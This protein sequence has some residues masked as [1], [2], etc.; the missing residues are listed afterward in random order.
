MDREIKVVIGASYGDEG[1]GFMTDY[2]CK[3]ADKPCITVLHNG[4][5]QRG[6]TVISPD[7]RR[8]VF[9]HFG[10]GTFN[11]SD[12]YF[13]DSFI[14]NPMIF[15]QEYK[16]LK[17]DINI[18]CSPT[19]MWSTPFDMMINQIIEDSRGD[20]RHGSCG[21]GIWETIVRCNNSET[22][23]FP[24][25]MLM[26]K[27][28]KIDYLRNIRDKYMPARLKEVGVNKIPAEWED[29]IYRDSIITHFI[30]DCIFFSGKIKYAGEYIPE[31]YQSVVFE[32]GQGL[33]LS[34]DND[35][36]HTTPSFTG[37]ENPLRIINQLKG[38][39]NIEVC[40]VTRSYLTR[41]GAGGFPHEC[42]K[43]EINPDM[44]D[45]TNVPN[46]YQGTLRYGRINTEE[47]KHR[48]YAD[49]AKFSGFDNVKISLA[50]THLNETN[51]KIITTDGEKNPECIG[52][53][54]I[55]HS[56]SEKKSL[57]L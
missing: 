29:I 17:P 15:A 34:Q 51:R 6:H 28:D 41:H 37:A 22:L 27:S 36:P 25:F 2:F 10:S 16:E 45:I 18:Y 14:V 1:K 31:N 48:I 54:K 57:E 42:P 46:D 13:A 55:Y 38:D 4:G 7:G 35:N 21:Y 53:D 52:I 3:K 33:L 8:H 56:Y 43:A 30:D 12:T 19:C 40:Y 9:H 5:S 11:G 49:F 24:V 39:N 47:L 32:G 20:N 23:E 26:D 44:I 50:V